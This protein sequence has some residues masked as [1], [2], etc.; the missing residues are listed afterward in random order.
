LSMR[1]EVTCSISDRR[2]C[3]WRIEL[4]QYQ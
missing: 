3:V 2:V 1:L 4:P